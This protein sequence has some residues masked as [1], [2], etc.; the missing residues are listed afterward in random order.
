MTIPVDLK[1]RGRA[2]WQ[3]YGASN[4]DSP[5]KALVQETARCLD[6]LDRLDALLVG[7]R[8][9]WITI[10]VGESGE[11]TLVIDKILAERRQY[12]ITLKAL[13]LEIRQHGITVVEAEEGE[14]PTQG[15]GGLVDELK[16]QREIRETR[17]SESAG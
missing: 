6:T 7:C 10:T 5:S 12:Q 15:R 14:Q 17:E 8:D 16:R 11:I 1:E 9:D 3:A 13:L 2:L 4:L